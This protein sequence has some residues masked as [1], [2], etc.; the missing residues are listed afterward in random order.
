VHECVLLQ[1]DVFGMI[2]KVNRVRSFHGGFFQ[3]TNS[4]FTLFSYSSN[5]RKVV[6][7][8]FSFSKIFYYFLCSFCLAFKEQ[9]AKASWFYRSDGLVTVENVGGRIES[10]SCATISN[11][12]AA[13]SGF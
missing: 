10:T 3:L 5:I 6:G 12:T 13:L 7:H 1:H 4:T 11:R 9:R 8:F 2:S